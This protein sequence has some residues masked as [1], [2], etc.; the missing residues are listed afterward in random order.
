MRHLAELVA[1]STILFAPFCEHAQFCI[2]ELMGKIIA[3]HIRKRGV[4]VLHIEMLPVQLLECGEQ[5]SVIRDNVRLNRTNGST[6]SQ[7]ST[8]AASEWDLGAPGEPLV[9]AQADNAP[10][11]SAVAHPIS[12]PRN[13]RRELFTLVTFVLRLEELL[14]CHSPTFGPR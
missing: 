13:L 14:R 2:G 11:R 3:Y 9:P 1:E 5:I 4:R 6:A 7:Y 12:H 8:M 10:A